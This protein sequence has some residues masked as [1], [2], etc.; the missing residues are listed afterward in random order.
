MPTQTEPL[1]VGEAGLMEVVRQRANVLAAQLRV[2]EETRRYAELLSGLDGTEYVTVASAAR[3][4]GVTK[5]Y[6]TSL[7]HKFQRGELDPPADEVEAEIEALRK[8]A[9]R[10]GRRLRA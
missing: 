8:E 3:A 7:V 1:P 4:S 10:L 5:G 6:A 9:A 2:K